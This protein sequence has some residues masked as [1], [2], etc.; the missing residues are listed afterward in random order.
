MTDGATNTVV[1]LLTRPYLDK[2]G[3]M[4]GPGEM[5]AVDEVEARLLCSASAAVRMQDAAGYDYTES[6]AASRHPHKMMTQAAAI[7]KG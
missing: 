1:V 5:V 6:K 2:R 3:P 4:F 7:T